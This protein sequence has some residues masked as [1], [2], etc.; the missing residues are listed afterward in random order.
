MAEDVGP[1]RR[2][3]GARMG[4]RSERV[5]ASVLAAVLSELAR[6]GY[7]ALRLEDVAIRAGVAKT[8]VYRRWPTKVTLVHAAIREAGRYDEPLPDTGSLRMDMLAMLERSMALVGTPEG[9][10]VAR[11]VTTD[12]SD[13]EVQ[14]L[15]HDLREETRRLRA[16]VVV[17]AQ[18]RGEIPAGV[19]PTM[20]TDTVFVFAISR[21]L[22]F[23]ER[24]D[25]EAC[26][27]LIDLVVTGAEHGGGQRALRRRRT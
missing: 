18:E 27:R 24:L 1:A 3:T 9:R 14:A 2:T 5:V 8:T 12:S 4:G 7:D 17:R 15:C 16:R 6:V 25:R 23:G 10:A 26:E 13:P 20:V 21:L 11:M 22:R 19:D